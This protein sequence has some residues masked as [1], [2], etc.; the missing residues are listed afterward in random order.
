MHP[1]DGTVAAAAAVELADGHA[2]YDAGVGFLVSKKTDEDS[3][4]KVANYVGS[5]AQKEVPVD[6]ISKVF[7]AV[8]AQLKKDFGVTSMPTAWRTAKATAF[9]ALE[10]GVPLLAD[11]AARPK[12]EVS[13]QLKG[14]PTPTSKHEQ[15]LNALA[16][17][18]YLINELAAE[19][20]LDRSEWE[21]LASMHNLVNE[22]MAKLRWA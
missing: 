6:T 13:K 19:K 15:C 7:K 21:T 18:S 20:L 8:E 11:G 14:A 17:A 4:A 10:K 22:S 12:T 2:L 9:G 3:W 16:R 5:L 1:D